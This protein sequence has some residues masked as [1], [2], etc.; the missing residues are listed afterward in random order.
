VTAHLRSD[1][2]IFEARDEVGIPPHNSVP[3]HLL[4]SS[5]ITLGGG[6]SL[7][8]NRAV[9]VGNG[10]VGSVLVPVSSSLQWHCVRS[11]GVLLV[12]T[13]GGLLLCMR[14]CGAARW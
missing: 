14:L 6:L 2:S 9:H 4:L 13:G 11:G 1:Q 7:G 12:L 8:D 5:A 10:L 3:S